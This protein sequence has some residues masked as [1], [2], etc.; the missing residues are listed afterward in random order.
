MSTIQKHFRKLL[1]KIN[2]LT[3][4][5]SISIRAFFMV[6]VIMK[7]IVLLDRH[8]ITKYALSATGGAVI[9]KIIE[10]ILDNLLK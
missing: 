7:L 4:M 10:I 5:L 1:E 3:A 6:H 2:M 8:P 9:M